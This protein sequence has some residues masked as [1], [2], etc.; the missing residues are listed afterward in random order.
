[1]HHITRR[2]S[3]SLLLTPLLA[4][5]QPAS[6]SDNEWKAFLDWASA[7]PPD[8]FPASGGAVLNAYKA[9]LI[10]DGLGA[11]DAEQLIERLRKR[12]NSG[13]EFQVIA[14]NKMYGSRDSVY[15]TAPNSLLVEVV[16]ELRP[17]R[18]LDV[19]MGE[20]RNSI[21]L[22]QRGW[23]VTGIDL[24][25]VG[26]AKAR[27]RASELGLRINALVLDADK[28]DYG[29][30][31]WDLVSLLY[32][33]GAMFVHDFEKRIGISVK[34]SGYII[35]EG[36]S[37]DPKSLGDGWEIWE[38]MG[39]KILRLEY[40]ASKAEWGQPSFSRFLIQKTVG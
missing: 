34:P 18:A 40:R 10:T 35:G 9:K 17:G 21:F 13:P 14:Y 28:F 38:G 11:A 7:V 3:L 19:G 20:G 27:K 16:Q 8:S 32:F 33:S 15:T 22:A 36:P 1:M 26:V 12:A 23:D 29:T 31:Q 4:R 30:Q 37:G 39:F 5:G 2:S 6:A 25:E 24:A